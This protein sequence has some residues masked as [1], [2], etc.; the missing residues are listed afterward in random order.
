MASIRGA[1]GRLRDGK[2]ASSLPRIRFEQ[3]MLE[4]HVVSWQKK[5]IIAVDFASSQMHTEDIHRPEPSM[6]ALQFYKLGLGY[7]LF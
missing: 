6:V 1:R 3:E 5:A 4:E 7:Y 2:P